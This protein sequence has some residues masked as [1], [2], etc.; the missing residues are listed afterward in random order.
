MLWNSVSSLM[1]MVIA[2]KVRLSNSVSQES[3]LKQCPDCAT[4]QQTRD[5]TNPVLLET[6]TTEDPLVTSDVQ[7]VISPEPLESS[8]ES[9]PLVFRT[10]QHNQE[11]M[12]AEEDDGPWERTAV[13]DSNDDSY[14]SYLNQ[15]SS[16]LAALMEDDTEKSL[17]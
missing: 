13:W 6:P 2:C 17:I 5:I 12:D 4:S 10:W 14:Q 11:F 7:S 9:L 8:T 16:I 1:L 15:E 3:G